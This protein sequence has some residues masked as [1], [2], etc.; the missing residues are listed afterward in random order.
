MQ[1]ADDWGDRMR[2]ERERLL[3]SQKELAKRA[4]ISQS[5]I[6]LWESGKRTPERETMRK[7][8]RVFDEERAKEIHA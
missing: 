7:V 3:L 4:G 6:S 8:K 1:E 5:T 2:A